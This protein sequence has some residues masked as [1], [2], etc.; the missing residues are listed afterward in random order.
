ML[1]TS[2]CGYQLEEHEEMEVQYMH[3]SDRRIQ[4]SIT[5][6]FLSFAELGKMHFVLVMML[7]YL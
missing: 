1:K 6:E 4:N 7:H 2:F 5:M 3:N